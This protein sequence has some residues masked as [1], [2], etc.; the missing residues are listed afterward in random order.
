MRFSAIAATVLAVVMTVSAETHVITVGKAGSL[1][2]E[3]A[4]VT[5]KSG[6]VIEFQLYDLLQST[7]IHCA[8][9]PL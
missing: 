2:Y 7:E 1:L 3:P 8:N 9:S 6:D 5:A 4:S